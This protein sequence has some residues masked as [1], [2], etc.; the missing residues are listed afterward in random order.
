MQD[1]LNEYHEIRTSYSRQTPWQREQMQNARDVDRQVGT[2][3]NAADRLTKSVNQHIQN[4]MKSLKIERT[5]PQTC[6]VSIHT[7]DRNSERVDGISSKL[8]QVDK[9]RNVEKVG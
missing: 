8:K 7:H 9:R 3:N 4:M 6:N 2:K 5:D 1:I